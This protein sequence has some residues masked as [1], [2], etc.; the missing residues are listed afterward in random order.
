MSALKLLDRFIHLGL[1]AIS[2][3]QPARHLA[4]C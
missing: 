4:Y 1:G 2:V 3:L